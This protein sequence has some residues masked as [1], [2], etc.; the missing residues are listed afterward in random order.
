[1]SHQLHGELLQASSLSESDADLA[2]AAD[3]AAAAAAAAARSASPPVQL[4]T[5]QQQ[6]QQPFAAAAAATVSAPLP[7]VTEEA[8]TDL[9][10]DG[11]ISSN[12]EAIVGLSTA[13]AGSSSSSTLQHQHRV[14]R[15]PLLKPATAVKQQGCGL[16]AV[17]GGSKTA[18]L[19]V[20]LAEDN[21]INMKVS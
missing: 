19:R 21:A 2:D 17:A 20:L 1:M 15:L 4:L 10:S 6:Q 8:A 16:D 11:S 7:C 12:P 13:A 14:R 18:A 5:Q 9:L 3:S